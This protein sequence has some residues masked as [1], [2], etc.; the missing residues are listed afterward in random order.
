[1]VAINIRSLVLGA[2]VA[3][4]SVT[5][6]AAATPF[7][8]V[9]SQWSE[10][11]YSGALPAGLSITCTGTAISIGALSC[12]DSLTVNRLV[13]SNEMATISHGG[14]IQVTNT[15]TTPF[16]G[17]LVFEI[18]ATNFNPGGPPVGISIDN[19]SQSASFS[20]ILV[21]HYTDDTFGPQNVRFL[22]LQTSCAVPAVSFPGYGFGG[23]YYFSALQCGLPSPDEDFFF[24][25]IS[26]DLLPGQ[27]QIVGDE[28]LEISDTFAGIPEPTML[29]IFAPAL[30]ALGLLRRRQVG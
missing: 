11:L 16:T 2:V 19:A 13:T 25:M 15:G 26:F 7:I 22:S 18:D 24:P 8:D 27:S 6:P 21:T 4:V 23:G 17:S 20:S 3:A 12:F 9:R 1:M 14:S 29:G 5:R 28:S 10:I 30:L